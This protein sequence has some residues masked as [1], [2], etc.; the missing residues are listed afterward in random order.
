MRFGIRGNQQSTHIYNSEAELDA[1][2]A[3]IRD[4]A[5]T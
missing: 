3:I 1:T 2:L 5:K 4:L